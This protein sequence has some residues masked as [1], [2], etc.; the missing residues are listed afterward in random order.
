MNEIQFIALTLWLLLTNINLW[1]VI[2]ELRNIK[3]CINGKENEN[4][5]TQKGKM[6]I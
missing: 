4:D 1:T 5:K 2:A 6:Y 3:R